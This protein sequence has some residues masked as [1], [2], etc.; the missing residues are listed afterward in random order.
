MSHR[1]AVRS[2][3]EGGNYPCVSCDLPA[4]SAQT[5]YKLDEHG[6]DTDVRGFAGYPAMTRNYAL[7]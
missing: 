5:T 1:G 7:F 2:T 4:R 3:P 6:Y